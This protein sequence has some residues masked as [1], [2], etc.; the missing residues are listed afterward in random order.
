MPFRWDDVCEMAFQ[1]IKREIA[2]GL[3]CYIFNPSCKTILTTDAS[4]VGIGA[5]LSQVQD[6]TEVPIA[7]AS[8]S[9]NERERRMAV[10]EKEAYAV[11]W[12]FEYFEKYLLG[13]STTL[14]TDHK[15]LTT[16]LARTTSTRKSQKF[17][18]WLERLSR[19]DYVIEYIK[20]NQN[21]AA[22]FLSRLVARSENEKAFAVPDDLS[23][24]TVSQIAS[25][26]NLSFK[27]IQESTAADSTLSTLV[28]YIHDNT[29]PVKSAL[30][31]DL[32]PFF[33]VQT[34][35]EV[36]DGIVLRN[37]T[38]VVVPKALYN[39]VLDIAHQGHP[40]VVRMKR[41]LRESYW[42]PGQCTQV[43]NFVKHCVGCQSSS[44][45]TPPHNVPVTRVPAPTEPWSRVGIDICGPFATAPYRYR[46]LVVMVDHFSGYPLVLATSQVTSSVIVTWLKEKFS[47]FGNPSELVSDNGPQFAS[48]EFSDFL[49]AHQVL[50][51]RSAVYN[52]QENGKTEVFNRFLKAGVQANFAV[53]TPW[54]EGI[55]LLLKTYRATSPTPS[56][57]SPAE[58][59]LSR[60]PR[61][62]LHVQRPRK[63]CERGDSESLREECKQQASSV[64]SLVARRYREGDT[65][66]V[67]LPDSWV[68]KGQSPW[69]R[70]LNVVQVLGR[71]SYR[72]SDRSKRNARRIKPWYSP[73]TVTCEA[74]RPSSPG[75]QLR[76]STRPRCPPDRYGCSVPW[77]SLVWEK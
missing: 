30:P 16:L 32:K 45:S 25:G 59:F 39:V 55:N 10:N 40:G 18:R 5:V 24:R 13:H 23:H 70:P 73:T 65:V 44:K 60:K 50:H 6:G 42:W 20:G 22:D 37:G 62:N 49:K 64:G 1:T 36:E 54:L 47:E 38:R 15:A 77:S 58:L 61:L 12:A 19:F 27:V 57:P 68:R 63:T 48:K 34:E 29:W 21:Q 46:F 28:R 53:S 9:L 74:A 72:L 66:V 17:E 26:E 14:R 69:S 4:D 76:R 52:P 71:Y 35:L 3:K 51:I 43:E 33:A 56:A 11:L 41:L 7:F 67:R 8:H 31:Y 2:S 75:Q